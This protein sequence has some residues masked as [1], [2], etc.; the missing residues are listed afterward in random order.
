M[1]K[2]QGG[3]QK[4]M[5]ICILLGVSWLIPVSEF[6]DLLEVNYWTKKCSLKIGGPFC[7]V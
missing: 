4:F 6:F 3:S 7:Y 5:D 1:C 2:S